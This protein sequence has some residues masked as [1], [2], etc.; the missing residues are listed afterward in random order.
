MISFECVNKFILEDINL[1]I[2]E[3]I[4]AG[5]AG[6]SGAGK[7]TLL[8]LGCGL[9][10]CESGN[11]WTCG[12]DPVINRKKI[13]LFTRVLFSDAPIFQEDSTIAYEFQ[14]LCTLYRIGQKEFQEEYD[15]LAQQLGFREYEEIP[16]RQL[17]LGQRRRAELA[18][19][20]FGEARLIFL[21]EPTNGLDEFGKR[22]FWELLKEKK[23]SGCVI[24]MVSHNIAE[25][26]GLCDR[27]ILLDKGRLLY[28]GELDRLMRKYAPFHKM[29][30]K[31]QGTLPDMEDLPFIKY[32]VEHDSLKLCYHSGTISAAEILDHIM[33]QTTVIWMKLIRPNLQDVISVIHETSG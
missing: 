16:V 30:I 2:P 15:M 6:P 25:M 22:T 5:I 3:G 9:L 18:A 20:L 17:S 31:F 11:I 28:Y 8:R 14:K 32:S 7:T 21:D 1:H 24:V 13:A 29:E 27:I 19:V 4:I 23:M 10:Q 26:E 33:G 12:V